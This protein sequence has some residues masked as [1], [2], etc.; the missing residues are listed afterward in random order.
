VTTTAQT[1]IA[2]AK[3]EVGFKEGANNQSKYGAWY[4]LDHQPWCAMFVSWVFDQAKCLPLIA[5][6]KKGFAGCEV[7]EEWA[8]LKGMVLP[9]GMVQPGDIL[10]FDFAH[11][12]KSVHTGI[13][14]GYDPN[15]HLINTVEGNTSGDHAGSQANGD[16]VYLKYR[17][18]STVRAVVRPKWTA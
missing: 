18:T 3:K 8:R 6:T 16:G 14:I 1:V 4:G 15:T 7:F 10:L 11:A 2:L 12:G 17:A 5:Q 9:V 13:A